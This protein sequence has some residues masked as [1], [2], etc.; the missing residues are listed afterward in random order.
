MSWAFLHWEVFRCFPSGSDGKASSYNV[1]D[2]G[3]IP[4]LGRSPGEENGNPLQYSCLENSID[5]GAWWTTVHGVAKSQTRLSDFFF[6]SFFQVL[7]SASLQV[8]TNVLSFLIPLCYVVCFYELLLFKTASLL[9][10]SGCYNPLY[11]CV[12]S[13]D[14][15]FLTYNSIILDPLFFLV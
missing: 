15:S 9:A 5:R 7:N 1:G 10:Y 14:I 2:L 6:L 4:G 13:Y 3:S 12:I 11:F 8:F